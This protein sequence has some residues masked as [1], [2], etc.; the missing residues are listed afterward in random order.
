MVVA[1]ETSP[2]PIHGMG[3]GRLTWPADDAA[4]E[5]VY[6]VEGNPLPLEFVA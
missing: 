4:V 6:V 2:G 1:V 5:A 3:P